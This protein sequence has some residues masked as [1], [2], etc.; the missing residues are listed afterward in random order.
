MTASAPEAPQSR[1]LVINR[2]FGPIVFTWQ[3]ADD[4][5]QPRVRELPREGDSA[6][7]PPKRPRPP[8][9][10]ILTLRGKTQRRKKPVPTKCSP[11]E[12]TALIT[13][14]ERFGED[15]DV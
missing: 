8:L 2:G 4:R 6:V 15:F 9:Q 13:A 3:I 12:I 5:A 1:E 7:A 14:P 10:A 11:E